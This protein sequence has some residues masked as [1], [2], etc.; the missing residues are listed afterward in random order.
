MLSKSSGYAIRALTHI[1]KSRKEGEKI[2]LQEI[3]NKLE[4]PHP[5]V[6]K[7]L[8]E[9]VK[10]NLLGSTKG[11]HGGFF[12]K[13]ETFE[14][15][16]A[17]VVEAID[18]PEFLTRCALSLPVCSETQPCPIHSFI[19]PYRSKLNQILRTTCIGELAA[20]KLDLLKLGDTMT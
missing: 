1:I 4:I 18:G 19:A 6:G 11:P 10:R 5:Y 9:L 7:L 17:S 14:A 8:Q 16:I 3:A 12:A 20:E 2:G 15:T 13:K